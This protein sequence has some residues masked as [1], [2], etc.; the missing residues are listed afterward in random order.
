[1]NPEANEHDP[2]P[3]TSHKPAAEQPPLGVC[4]ADSSAYLEL[5][6]GRQQALGY[7]LELVGRGSSGCLFAV[8]SAPTARDADGRTGGTTLNPWADWRD[9]QPPTPG[10]PLART[11]RVIVATAYSREGLELQV[12]SLLN[13][14]LAHDLSAQG[15]SGLWFAVLSEPDTID[16][17]PAGY[18]RAA[19]YGYVAPR[20]H[21]AGIGGV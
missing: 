21:P 19:T 13:S 14:G 10:S 9:P 16:D 1:L 11:A 4:Q 17:A 6:I 5:Q 3:L 7:D 15:K 18:S 8:L 12:R 2:V 20:A